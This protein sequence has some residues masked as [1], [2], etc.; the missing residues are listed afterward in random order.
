MTKRTID[1][2]GGYRISV[3]F[4]AD[5]D[6]HYVDVFSPGDDQA[7]IVWSGPGRA[8]GRLVYD[9]LANA[10]LDGKPELVH[11]IVADVKAKR[12]KDEHDHVEYYGSF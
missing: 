11:K 8:E 5:E 9:E 4:W 7:E 10:L 6:G 3:N 12:L 2:I 1:A